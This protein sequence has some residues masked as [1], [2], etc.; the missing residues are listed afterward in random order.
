MIPR[1]ARRPGA[2][3]EKEAHR[4]AA[5]AGVR[6]AREVGRRG[7]GA[8]RVPQV[9]GDA[10]R[11]RGARQG[12]VAEVGPRVLRAHPLAQDHGPARVPRARGGRLGELRRARVR[13]RDARGVREGLRGVPG[14]LLARAHGALRGHGQGARAVPLGPHRLLP[15]R[16]HLPRRVAGRQAVQVEGGVAPRAAALGGDVR[17]RGISNPEVC[18]PCGGATSATSSASSRTGAGRPTRRTASALRAVGEGTP[19]STDGLRGHARVLPRLG[20]S[21]HDAT[22]AREARHGELGMAVRDAR[23]AR[24]LPG[25]P[26]GDLDEEARPLSRLVPVGRAD[27]EVGRRQG[28]HPVGPGG[29]RRLRPHARRPR[30]GAAAVLVLLGGETGHVNG[31]L[32]ESTEKRILHASGHPDCAF[33]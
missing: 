16:R 8:G 9:R 11:V 14:H 15:G 22:P 30:E 13:G 32:T 17:E 12:R 27:E 19:V 10:P 6:R 7:P 3:R 2:R 20:V 25:A 29:D 24:G 18:V 31:G 5:R 4:P 21:R 23:E 28:G 33:P 26:R 1:E